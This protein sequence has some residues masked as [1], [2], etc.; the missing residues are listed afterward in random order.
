PQR[1]SNLLQ[2]YVRDGALLRLR[3]VSQRARSL[4]LP[5]SLTHR[6]RLLP[7]GQLPVSHVNSLEQQLFQERLAKQRH[8]VLANTRARWGFVGFG[9]VPLAAVEIAGLATISWWFILV[10]AASFA[11][12]NAGVRRLVQ[13]AEFKPWYPQLNLFVG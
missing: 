6:R 9:I 4:Q 12:A 3:L 7:E 8:Y 1:R 10:F 13:G 5:P 2:A 11:G